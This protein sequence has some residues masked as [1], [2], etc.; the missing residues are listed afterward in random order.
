MF[1]IDHRDPPISTIYVG[2]QIILKQ[3]QKTM[4]NQTY[5]AVAVNNFDCSEA[6]PKGKRFLPFLIGQKVRVVANNGIWAY[7][8]CID[9][10]RKNGIFPLSAVQK[11]TSNASNSC[12]AIAEPCTSSESAAMVDEITLVLQNW[13]KTCKDYYTKQMNVAS[14]EKILVYMNDLMVVRKQILSGNVPAEELKEIRIKTTSKIDLGNQW[15]GL[16]MTIRDTGG[17]PINTSTISLIQCY[18]EHVSS[19][20]KIEDDSRPHT[21]TQISSFSVLIQVLSTTLELACDCEFVMSLY[22]LKEQ[23]FITEDFTFRWSARTAGFEQKD[24]RVFF[25]GFGESEA[26]GDHRLLIVLRTYRIAPIESSSSTMK[27]QADTVGLACYRQPYAVGFIDLTEVIGGEAPK[28]TI[29]FLSRDESFDSLV[30]SL[31][32]SKLSTAKIL[33]SFSGSGYA[34]K[35]Q[36]MISSQF[37]LG[38]RKQIKKNFPHIFTVRP[39]TEVYKISDSS[40]DDKPSNHLF[41]TLQ[42]GEFYKASEKNIEARLFL[43]SNSNHWYQNCFELATPLEEQTISSHYQSSVF[44][45]ED[46]PKWN[47]TVKI[48]L[49]DGISEH[50]VHLRIALYSRRSDKNKTDKGPFAI[51]F[52]HILTGNKLISDGEHE[53]LMYKVDPLRFAHSDTTY[54]SNPATRAEMKSSQSSTKPVTLMEK[55]SVTIYTRTR[56]TVLTHNIL[57][58]GILNWQKSQASLR[59]Y[60]EKIASQEGLV[61]E[62]VV[63][64]IPSFFDAIF[65]IMDNHVNLQRQ[66]FDV[67]VVVLRLVESEKNAMYKPVLDNY[68][69]TFHSTVAYVG[70][71]TNLLYYIEHADETHEKSLPALKALGY[72]MRMIV[73]SM[74]AN[75][76]MH[77]S[78]GNFRD[79][80][81]RFKIALE[82]MMQGDRGRMTC[83]NVALKFLPTIIP[84]LI[85]P[86]ILEP[87][88]VTVFIISIMDKFGINIVPRHRLEFIEKVVDTDL[89]LLP[90]CREI[91]LSKVLEKVLQHLEPERMAERTEYAERIQSC[92]NILMNILETLANMNLSSTQLEDS[93]FTFVFN[94]C[95]RPLVQ[96]CIH[97]LHERAVLQPVFTIVLALLDRISAESF[98]RCVDVLHT[99][100]DKLDFLSELVR[101]FRDIYSRSA[102]QKDWYL[103]LRNQNKIFVKT[104]RFIIPIVVTTFNDNNFD[105]DLWRECMLTLVAF[106][107][108]EKFVDRKPAFLKRLAALS[109]RSLWYQIPSMEKMNYIPSLVGAFL[110]VALTND[111]AIRETTIP[112]FFDM[113]QIEYHHSTPNEFTMFRDEMIVQLDSL[114]DDGG[115]DAAFRRQLHHLMMDRCRSNHEMFTRGGI[116]LFIKEIDHLLQLLFDY[117]QVRRMSDSIENGMSRTVALIKYYHSIGQRDLYI[118]YVYKLYDLHLL[119][120]NLVEAAFTLQSHASTLSWEEEELP[121]F[122]ITKQLN[123]QCG[124]QRQLKEQLYIEMADLLDRG[125]I[126]EKSIEILKELVPV[127]EHRYIDYVKLSELLSRIA[128]LYRKISSHPRMPC[129]YFLVGFYGRDFPAYLNKKEFV[130]RGQ[131]LDKLI[132]FQQRLLSTFYGSKLVPTMDDCSCLAKQRG[133]HIQIIAVKPIAPPCSLIENKVVNRLIRW[134]YEHNDVNKFEYSRPEKRQ[135]KFTELE[136]S[137][138]TQL[139]IRKRYIGVDCALPNILKFSQVISHSEPFDSS[140]LNEAVATMERSNDGLYSMASEAMNSPDEWT[141]PLGGAIRGVL[142]ANVQ[143]GTKNYKVFFTDECHAVLTEEELMEVERLGELLRNQVPIL[144]YCLYVHGNMPKI[145]HNFHASLVES[146]YEYRQNIEEQFGS[147]PSILPPNSSILSNGPPAFHDNSPSVTNAASLGSLH[148]SRNVISAIRGMRPITSARKSSSRCEERTSFQSESSLPTTPRNSDASRISFSTANPVAG[149][150]LRARFRELESEK[151][152]ERFSEGDS[153]P[154]P[155]L[156]SDSP[157]STRLNSGNPSIAP[158]NQLLSLVFTS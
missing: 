132:S 154:P 62:Q 139:W 122:V 74:R 133:R 85:Q 79:L 61:T 63:K 115:G 121:P 56:S 105:V 21:G 153:P 69:R 67:L 127:Y 53:L 146:F 52:A 128:D 134:Y 18:R 34:Q 92:S 17:K 96:T 124:S 20:K 101:M 64:F 138:V 141:K 97:L 108:Q 118:A 104:M 102:Y 60:L 54:V 50:D 107:T 12:S 2:C 109:L 87:Y 120:G 136:N 98:K 43:Y 58:L 11:H 82:G 135:S 110:R 95:F 3:Q 44:Y 22:D 48:R 14:L 90:E 81:E 47:E 103:M 26:S 88:E 24:C 68:I 126:W 119:C 131:A 57:I 65:G 33:S 40:A 75:R 113:V 15:L 23:K 89:F 99:Q 143:G 32:S 73:A 130:F 137:E 157:T 152:A 38:I 35:T 155:P 77:S 28:E 42:S 116:V 55:N 94:K 29:F 37:M 125:E 123:R 147:A 129:S 70:L 78:C 140:P 142:Q 16:D 156:P 49:P 151:I 83:Q 72:L 80:I 158:R 59:D 111:A 46:K 91:L 71:I 5:V 9:D 145:D 1:P 114:V 106:I 51:A 149:S 7:G 144:E 66:C 36:V 150:P 100:L 117:R 112:I 39:P 86:G 148:K 8:F 76:R 30:A 10:E 27:K 93:D 41:V 13:W 19:K 45:H 6:L 4:Q 84:E 31:L 25:T